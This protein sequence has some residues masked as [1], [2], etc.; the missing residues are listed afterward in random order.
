LVT[1]AI[2]SLFSIVEGTSTAISD[3]F[4]LNK[5]K[6]T[7]AMC[8]IDGAIGLFFVTGAGL[9]WLDIVDNWANSYTLILTGL[10]EA[11]V[12]GWCFKTSKILNEVN[13][14]TKKFKMPAWWFNI[15]I[16]FVAPV[17][18]VGLFVWNIVS[19]VK[20]GGIYGAAD[21]YSLTANIIGG[22]AIMGLCLVS[23]GI[24][25]IVAKAKAKKG[26][27]EDD[28]SWDDIVAADKA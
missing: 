24:V 19:L 22:W 17:V 5:R 7:L 1:L 27:V 2:D 18:L 11:V 8:I 25:M 16:K 14:N 23:G 6:T 20:G 10:L 9:A 12:V 21:G 3:K 4:K 28:R 26:F 15:S 13:L